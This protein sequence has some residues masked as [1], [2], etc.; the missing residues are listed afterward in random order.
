[1]FDDDKFICMAMRG[2]DDDQETVDVGE[3]WL[4]VIKFG[5]GCWLAMI[6]MSFLAIFSGFNEILSKVN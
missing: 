4:F 1:M 6:L 2:P 5:F 3:K